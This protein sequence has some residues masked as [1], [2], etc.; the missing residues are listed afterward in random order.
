[1]TKSKARLIGWR[2]FSRRAVHQV[3]IPWS[4]DR[5]KNQISFI[6]RGPRLMNHLG[7]HA[8]VGAGTQ[9]LPRSPAVLHDEGA[10]ND[11]VRFV[12]RVPVP[13]RMIILWASDQEL[14][15]P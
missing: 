5:D 8:I 2:H 9:F 12:R 7:G 13:W 6:G 3:E 1:M 11:G 15:S 14:C 4:I 10:A